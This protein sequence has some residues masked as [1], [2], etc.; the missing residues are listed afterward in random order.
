MPFDSFV[1]S[2]V[3]DAVGLAL[4]V[5]SA[6]L[7]V[8]VATAVGETFGVACASGVGVTT[9]MLVVVVTVLA[10]AFVNSRVLCC[11]SE[12]GRGR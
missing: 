7:A 9:D 5:P 11:S 4:G 12:N 8:G 10:F 2:G 3:G 1:R 6:A